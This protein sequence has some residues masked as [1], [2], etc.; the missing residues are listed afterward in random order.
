MMGGGVL[1]HVLREHVGVSPDA[2]AGILAAW[3]TKQAYISESA[4]EIGTIR[5][6]PFLRVKGPDEERIVPLKP[7]PSP[8]VAHL[9]EAVAD[10]EETTE[11]VEAV[12]NELI[13]KT[14]EAVQKGGGVT[15]IRIEVRSYYPVR[16]TVNGGSYTA[17]VG[18]GEGGVY[19]DQLPARPSP[20]AFR[21]RWWL[22]ALAALMIAEAVAVPG[23]VPAVIA[24]AVTAALFAGYVL[25]RKVEL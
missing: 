9:G 20:T 11:T 19:P 12:D 13:G 3:L 21:G 17:V 25:L 24:V 6:F 7:L 14:I 1:T 2:A 8:A 23:L 18:A 10:L 22:V 4:P 5:S 16:Y 15:A